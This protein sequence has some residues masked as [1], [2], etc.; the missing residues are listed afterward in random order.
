[1]HSVAIQYAAV[2]VMIG[3][4]V[5]TCWLLRTGYSIRELSARTAH[6]VSGYLR[7]SPD[8]WLEGTLRAA[9]AEFDRELA[10]ILKERTYAAPA[11][12]D[13]FPQD[14]AAPPS[15]SVLSEATH[16]APRATRR[17]H[18]GPP[19]ATCARNGRTRP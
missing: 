7:T 8:P 12:K 14:P 17:S 19:P 13:K 1:V 4:G 15:R 9:F 5:F 6:G 16:T 18:D 10:L 11:A 2:V 3:I